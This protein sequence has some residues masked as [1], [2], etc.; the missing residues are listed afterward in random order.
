MYHLVLVRCL[1][2]G[3]LVELVAQDTKLPIDQSDFDHV[4]ALTVTVH[5]AFFPALDI[6]VSIHDP[7]KFESHILVFVLRPPA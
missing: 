1:C 2:S 5:Y 3:L 7:Y 6:F 4:C